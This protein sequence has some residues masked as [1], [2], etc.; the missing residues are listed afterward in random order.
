MT[1]T[2]MDEA[3]AQ[4]LRR[5]IDL[6]RW[7]KPVYQ[8]E[9]LKSLRDLWDPSCRRVL[10][11]GGGTGVIAQ[12]VHELLPVE[13]VASVDVHDRFLKTLTV[14]TRVYDGAR[15]PFDDGEFD[16]GLINNVIHHIPVES[17]HA[18]LSECVRVTGRGP[19]FVKDHLAA[20]PLDHLRLIALDLM[21]NLPFSGMLSAK[22]LD[23][24]QWLALA[25][26][27]G[28]RIERRVSGAYRSG[29]FAFVFPNRLEVTMK[30]LPVQ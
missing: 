4:V 24:G 29:P 12:T 15:I 1:D 30:W 21:G 3:V 28:Y 2:P 6:Y 17:R 27:L 22:Y 13:R 5:H 20:S 14:E 8:A 11:L 23:D 9:M 10:D 19:L 16:C 25:K 7:R 26:S 18:V